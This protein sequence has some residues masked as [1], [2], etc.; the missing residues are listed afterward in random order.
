MNSMTKD[1]VHELGWERAAMADH[2]RLVN[3]ARVERRARRRAG[4][5]ATGRRW[6]RRRGLPVGDPAPLAVAPAPRPEDVTAELGI[7]LNGIAERIAERGTA[8]ERL[9]LHAVHEA[10]RWSAPGAA[11][12]LVDWDGSETARLRAFGILHG[13]V[14]GTLGPEDRAWLLDRLR[15]TDSPRRIR[16]VA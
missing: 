6:L 15:G 8:T 4:R 7:L 16:Q 9:A 14:L 2:R 3:E 5:R 11:A 10:A 1:L 12:A 13:V